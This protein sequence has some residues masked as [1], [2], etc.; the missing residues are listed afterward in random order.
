MA[1]KIRPVQTSQDMPHATTVV[2]IG[3]GIVGLSAA[4]TLAERGI[5]TVVLEKGR[6][7]AE[8][9]SRNL[10][11]IRKTSRLAADIPLTQ[12]SDRLWAGMAERTGCDPGYRETGIMFVAGSE[13]EM[14]GHRRWLASAEGLDLGSKLLSAR[15]VDELSPGGQ[16]NWAGGVY[17]ASDGRAEPTLASSAIAEAALRKGAVIVENCAVRCLST[18]AGK[19]SG[20]VTERGEIACDQVILAGGLWSRRFLGNMGI[21]LPSLPLICYAFRTAPLEGP[22]EV[23]VGGPDFSFRKHA[24]GGYIGT[25]RAAFGS[26][27]VLDHFLLGLRYLDTLK[28]THRMIRPILGKPFIED[29]KL[30]R[31]WGPGDISPFERERTTDPRTK[32]EIPEQALANLRAAWPAFKD[33]RIVESWGGTMDITP[34]SMPVIS[35]VASVPGFTIATGFSGHGFGTGPGAGQLA[36]D[37][38]TGHAPLVD[39]SP[40][41]FVP[42]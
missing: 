24:D 18:A 11:W 28:E 25:H 37:L 19:V 12:A 15:E 30:P 39:P 5:P 23:A 6:I 29:L 13:A 31:R 33:T 9:S 10:G 36:A 34:S 7:A 21:S 14:E 17:T 4:L 8:Q 22:S 26:P 32:E 42:R 41:A 2:I 1:P 27:F 38:A 40:Y 16:G 35:P 3:G 20:V